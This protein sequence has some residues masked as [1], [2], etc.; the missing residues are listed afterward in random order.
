MR[1]L[2]TCPADQQAQQEEKHAVP[3]QTA[4]ALGGE[5]HHNALRFKST[6]AYLSKYLWLRKSPR[7]S[8]A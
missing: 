4:L 5:G 2:M 1:G 6:R 3:D 7:R 8:F